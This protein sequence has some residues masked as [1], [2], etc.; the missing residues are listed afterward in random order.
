MLP[1]VAMQGGPAPESVFAPHPVAQGADERAMT[2]TVLGLAAMF[3]RQAR[4]PAPPGLPT[5]RPFQQAQGE[6]TLAW[7]KER[8]GERSPAQ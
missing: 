8:L 6:Q 4:R 1:S 7:L 2:T 3:L 5:L